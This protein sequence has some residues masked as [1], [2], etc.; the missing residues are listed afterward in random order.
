MAK[1]SQEIA[2]EQ[3]GIAMH[4][5]ATASPPSEGRS[6]KIVGPNVFVLPVLTPLR[7]TVTKKSQSNAIFQGSI[8]LTDRRN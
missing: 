4:H 5:G 8:R 2:K 6:T 3:G 1:A 7:P